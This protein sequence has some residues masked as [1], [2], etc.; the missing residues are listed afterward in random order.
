MYHNRTLIKLG[1]VTILGCSIFI[2]LILGEI[3]VRLCG[4]VDENGN[5]FVKTLRCYPYHLPVNT[6]RREINKYLVS[7]DSYRVYD[8]NL[9]WAPRPRSKSKNGLYLY[10][11]CAIRTPSCD[12]VI[13]KSPAPGVLRILIFGDSFAHGDN[14]SFENTWGHYLEDVLKKQNINAE[15]LNFGVG[16]YGM[17]QAFLR[18]KAEG[19]VYKP[20]IVLF[21]L[22]LEDMD[23][24][25]NLIIPVYPGETRMPFTKPRFV[26][27][28]GGKLS[29]INVPTL[30]PNRL[31]YIMNDFTSWELAKYA[32]WYKSTEYQ[33]NLFFRSKLIAFVYSWFKS[34]HKEQRTY[35]EDLEG[36]SLKII[37]LFKE[38][39]EAAGGKFYVVYL[40]DSGAVNLLKKNKLSH[41]GFFKRLEGVAPVI[42]PEAQFLKEAVDIKSLTRGHYRSKANKAVADAVANF[43][44]QRNNQ[45][46]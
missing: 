10:N 18:W 35:G 36:L 13:S 9:G 34:Y 19:Y 2:A 12:T 8:R 29:L 17:D 5:F 26:L 42:H 7:K 24:N 33:E 3:A 25:V 14:V 40:P 16:G 46:D 38:D 6:M 27:E 39:V 44:I 20:S 11:E 32:Y 43:I 4:H 28:Q 1:L 30:D 37:T 31:V 15:V 45:K 23:R 41:A 22:R 21:G